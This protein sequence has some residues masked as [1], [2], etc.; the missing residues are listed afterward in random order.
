MRRIYLVSLEHQDTKSFVMA[1]EI[2]QARRGRL[3]KIVLDAHTSHMI[4]HTK[5]LDQSVPLKG[6]STTLVDALAKGDSGLLQKH[7]LCIVRPRE[8]GIPSWV[9]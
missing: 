3:S 8:N 7:G 1:L 6:I 9:S 4:F 5:E 2:L